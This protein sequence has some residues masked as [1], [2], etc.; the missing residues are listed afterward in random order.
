MKLQISTSARWKANSAIAA[1]TARPV[2][3]TSVR[4]ASSAASG[5]GLAPAV[6]APKFTSIVVARETRLP[7]SFAR[8]ALSRSTSASSEKFA[9][10][11]NGISRRTK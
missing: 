11:P 10:W 3:P 5:V 8:S 7:R 1:S 6:C 4:I 9:S 2:S